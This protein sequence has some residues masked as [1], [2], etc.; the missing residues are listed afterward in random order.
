MYLKKYWWSCFMQTFG[1]MTESSLHIFGVFLGL[2]WVQ[3][4]FYHYYMALTEIMT[5]TNIGWYDNVL[6]S[7]LLLSL[8]LWHLSVSINAITFQMQC[9]SIFHSYDTN[10]QQFS[11][12]NRACASIKNPIGFL[13]CKNAVVMWI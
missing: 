5:V 11:C 10:Y 7:I 2:A 13:W 1:D 4:G 8:T 3:P 6:N 12:D 9:S